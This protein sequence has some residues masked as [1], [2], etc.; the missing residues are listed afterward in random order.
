MVAREV[1]AAERATF[2]AT[3]AL[4]TTALETT[5]A[6]ETMTREKKK[7]RGSWKRQ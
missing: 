2:L 1:T 5:A 3:G 7:R 4:A 6:R